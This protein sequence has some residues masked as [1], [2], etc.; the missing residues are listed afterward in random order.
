MVF[1]SPV[2]SRLGFEAILMIHRMISLEITYFLKPQIR[3]NQI[4]NVSLTFPSIIAFPFKSQIL[5]C[6]L[7]LNNVWVGYFLGHVKSG[8][9]D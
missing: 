5:C 8:N 4:S 9:I 2:I 3:Y 6:I 1:Y 7:S